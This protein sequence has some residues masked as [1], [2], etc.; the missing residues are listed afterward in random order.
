MDRMRIAPTQH[1]FLTPWSDRFVAPQLGTLPPHVQYIKIM[2]IQTES[3]FP[4]GLIQ[5]GRKY[6]F[7][8]QSKTQTDSVAI[9]AQV[10]CSM[11]NSGQE[12]LRQAWL[13]TPDG[14]L[15]ALNQIKAWALRQVWQDGGKPAYGMLPHIAGHLEKAGP[16]GGQPT[17]KAVGQLLRVFQAAEQ[18]TCRI[19]VSENGAG[20]VR[21]SCDPRAILVRS[22]RFW[23]DPG[24]RTWVF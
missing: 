23:S 22:T 18:R 13:G 14:C 16:S 1:P 8:F 11:S 5:T 6:S 17:S 4:P 19:R 9:L 2:K 15:N 24:P 21:S 10:C 3:Q 12:A 20:L 7:P